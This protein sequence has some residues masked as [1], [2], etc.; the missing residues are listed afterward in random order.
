MFLADPEGRISIANPAF[1][2]ATGR[3]EAECLGRPI[4]EV[5]PGFV[6][7]ATLTAT[8]WNGR[9]QARRGSAQP[10]HLEGSITP[11]RGEDGQLL[12]L[13]GLFRDV[14]L[15]VEAEQNRVRGD[16]MEALGALASGVAHDFNNILTAILTAS[17]LIEWQL[18][19]DSEIR[20]KLHVIY[21]AVHRAQELNRQILSFSHSSEEKHLP[22]DLS[23]V[24]K[25][26][27]FLI[28]STFPDNIRL[29]TE[30]GSSLWITGDPSQAHQVVLNLAIN[31]FQAMQPDGGDLEVTLGEQAL[32]GQVLPGRGPEPLT[33]QFVVLTVKDSGSGIDAAHLARIFDP[34]FT[35]KG[36]KGGSGLGLSVVHGI[37]QKHQGAMEVQSQ[38]GQGST[39]RVLFPLAAQELDRTTA[40]STPEELGGHE[41]ILLVDDEEVLGAL[42]KQGL[43]LL[44]YRVTARSDSG[45]ALEEFR[46][47]P[48][49]FDL[50]ITDLAMPGMTGV[51]LTHRIQALCPDLPAIL[52][53]GAFQGPP[54]ME[55]IST[56]FADVIYKPV[57]IQDMA[58]TVRSVMALRP[59]PEPAPLAPQPEL[60]AA[61]TDATRVL[62]A[63]DSHVTRV[64]LR[65]WLAK[66]GYQV[67]E[68]QDGLE[69]WEAFSAARE[70]AGFDLVLT[71]IVMP[72]MDGLQLAARVR[73]VDRDI[74][75]VILS[76]SEDADSVKAAIHLQ[77]NEF[78][79]KPFNSAVLLD[80]VKRMS[81]NRERALKGLRSSETAQ[82]V[83]MAQRAMEAVPERDMP[84]YS[85]SEP[86]TDAGGDVF[87][88]HRVEGDSIFFAI[89][90]VAGHS[91]ISS[92][93][94][95]AYLGMLSN[96]VGE[97]RH[98][99][100]LDARPGAIADGCAPFG[101]GP[102]RPLHNLALKLNRTIQTGPFSEVPI[103]SLFGLWTPGCGRLHLLNAGIPHARWYQREF[104]RTVPVEINGTPLGILDDP[105]MDEQV[106]AMAPGDRLLLGSDGFFEAISPDKELFQDL[107]PGLWRDLAVTDIK[108]AINLVSEA[109]KVHTCGRFTDDFLVL[110]LEQPEFDIT[111]PHFA[112]NLPA[113][114]VQIDQAC[115]EL[116]EWVDH[117]GATISPTRRF[118]TLLAVREALSNAVLHASPD[119][120]SR[121]T[122]LGCRDP[123]GR[124]NLAVLDQGL[125]FDLDAYQP[126]D[127]NHSVRGRGIPLIRH[128]AN[129]VTMTGG[130][131]R[132]TFDLEAPK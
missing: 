117:C 131:L 57:S 92:Y 126:P 72:R 109:A 8:A 116:G 122:L 58:R 63:E 50:L 127:T 42:G 55:G 20:P 95:A 118:E 73:E 25:E 38:P 125:G 21:Q 28:K 34:F 68:C 113:G 69:A 56:P 41:R 115:Q 114:T 91:V 61:P 83:R 33:G 14:S 52:V 87:R 110:G 66:T 111:H 44:G 4:A 31:A 15:A 102:C 43:Q 1:L 2:A 104:A 90:D 81:Q 35:T 105:L 29:R 39:F 47:H 119:P 23:A 76:T 51:E 120:G 80:C 10:V 99:R 9:V 96:F 108:M 75:I 84:I 70:S 64:L 79:T 97:C 26:A 132:M 89:A 65:T 5:L 19:P 121:V 78:L 93:A 123:R 54:S 36:A 37:V 22:F 3:T 17:E 130:E 27:I 101:T 74:P 49:D 77:V 30:V 112:L 86:L 85:I 60:A 94:V 40:E 6:C 82:A 48:R 59:E 16:K 12:A 106:I 88:C 18:N 7:P 124:L 24:V 100:P 103:C 62:L 98:L 53:T 107:L 45:E 46:N 128:F 13:S 11:L 71:D 129:E 67:K 32:A